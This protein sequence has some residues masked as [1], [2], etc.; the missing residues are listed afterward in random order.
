MIIA[1]NYTITEG[2]EVRPN[3]WQQTYVLSLPTNKAATLK[4]VCFNSPD[5]VEVKLI[6]VNSKNLFEGFSSKIESNS[7]KEFLEIHLEVNPK[8]FIVIAGTKNSSVEVIINY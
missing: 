5:N 6:D 8:I 4:Q 3:F 1:Q 7:S 2:V